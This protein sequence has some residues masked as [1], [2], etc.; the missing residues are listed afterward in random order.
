MRNANRTVAPCIVRRSCEALRNEGVPPDTIVVK[1]KGTAGQSF[2]A[3]PRAACLELTGEAN[4]YVG[5][6]AFP[7]GALRGQAHRR[8]HGPRPLGQHHIVSNTVMYGA[9]SGEAY[10]SFEGWRA[11]ALRQGIQAR[12]LSWKALAIMAANT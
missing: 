1:L 5:K 7:A 10:F 8:V 2:G 11:S 6:G 3:F 9:T 4:D 12:R